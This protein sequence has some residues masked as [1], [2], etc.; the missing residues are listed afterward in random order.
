MS[1]ELGRREDAAICCEYDMRVV[2]IPAQ[3]TDVMSR[4]P[5]HVELALSLDRGCA[6]ANASI[7]CSRC[8]ASATATFRQCSEWIDAHEEGFANP[9][10]EFCPVSEFLHRGLRD[11][12][13]Q[14]SDQIR[15]SE[16][17][18]IS[19]SSSSKVGLAGDNAASWSVSR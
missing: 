4:L 3:L 19:D 13:R 11:N 10:P 18:R 16:R 7:R 8:I 1:F 5:V 15:V 2:T 9:V 6:F 14:D 12:P 17:P